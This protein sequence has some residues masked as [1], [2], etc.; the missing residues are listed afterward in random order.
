MQI[1]LS[2]KAMFQQQEELAKDFR[3]MAASKTMQSAVLHALGEMS[4]S[5]TM[6]S[7]QIVAVRDFI[8]VFLNLAE[9]KS[10]PSVFPTK[11]VSM[12]DPAAKLRK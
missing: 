12:T 2:P 1:V 5:Y 4:V 7:E 8:K 6:T 10:E 11:T 9:I 3:A